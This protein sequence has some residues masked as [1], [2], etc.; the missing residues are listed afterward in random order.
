MSLDEY[1]EGMK[2][3]QKQ[4]YYVTA[5]GKDKAQMSPAAEK[6]RNR[7]YEVL[8][9]TEPLDEIMIESVTE[10]KDFKLV[11]VSKEG[12]KFDDEDKEEQEKKEAE[13][14]E[15]HSAVKD[16][17]ESAL[18]GKVQKVKMTDMLAE[19]PAALVQGAYGMS[20]TM[21]RYMKAQNVASGGADMGMMGSFNQAV[22]EV[23]PSHPIVRDLERMVAGPGGTDG[24]EPKNFA[25]S[26]RGVAKFLGSS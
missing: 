20:P 22:L 7:G 6:V 18:A 12:L 10:Y 1:V 17:L 21:Q 5:D 2:E 16:F 9:L 23:N 24:E 11:D 8:Y 3:N 19:S 15:D 4:I 14:N 26:Y 25:T 13:L